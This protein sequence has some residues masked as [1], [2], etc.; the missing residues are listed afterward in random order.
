MELKQ[1]SHPLWKKKCYRAE[2]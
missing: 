1:Y 2:W